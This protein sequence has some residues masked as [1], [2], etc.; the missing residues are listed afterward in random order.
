MFGEARRR[1]VLR[2]LSRLRAVN[3]SRSTLLLR[4]AGVLSG[5]DLAGVMTTNGELGFLRLAAERHAVPKSAAAAG[6]GSG[7]GRWSRLR[8]S[9]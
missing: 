1:V 7:R 4:N 9:I 6:V 3:E 8:A 2:V 5:A